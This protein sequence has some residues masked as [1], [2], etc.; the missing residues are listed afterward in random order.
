[1][2]PIGH[3]SSQT[4]VSIKNCLSRK[5]RNGRHS[6]TRFN[7]ADHPDRV[8]QTPGTDVSMCL[9]RVADR[10]RSYGNQAFGNAPHLHID[11]P[12]VPP[13]RV[14]RT[15]IL[16]AEKCFL[17]S[18]PSVN[19]RSILPSINCVGVSKFYSKLQ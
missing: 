17:N 6:R 8:S 14:T 19:F 9:R 15:G 11:S 10:C 3:T 1:M 16:L 12:S 18:L 7:F 4:H 5:H 2:L 13:L